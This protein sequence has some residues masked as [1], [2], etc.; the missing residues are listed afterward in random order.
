M[1][2]GRTARELLADDRDG[3][4][5]L[6]GEEILALAG[7]AVR[8]ELI[9][10]ERLQL[11]NDDEALHLLRERARLLYREGIDHAH[12]EDGRLRHSLADILINDAAAHDAEIGAAHLLAVDVKAVDVRGEP[13]L[14][15]FDGASLVVVRTNTGVS[16]F[17]ESSNASFVNSFAS[18]LSAGSNMGMCALRA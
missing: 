1:T 17:S 11:L 13:V 9:L 15:R 2:G 7:D 18:A 3:E 4:F 6:L 16:Y 12:F 14:A 8:F 5:P 10:D